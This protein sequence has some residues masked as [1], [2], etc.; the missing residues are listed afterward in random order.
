MYSKIS[1]IGTWVTKQV[2]RSL[3]AYVIFIVVSG[4]LFLALIMLKQLLLIKSGNPL[5]SNVCS[6]MLKMKS[7][8]VY[9]ESEF[10]VSVCKNLLNI[11]FDGSISVD[12]FSLISINLVRTSLKSTLNLC[13][14]VSLIIS[15]TSCHKVACS[16]F[17]T[18]DCFFLLGSILNFSKF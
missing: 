17:L 16:S 15:I 12:L 8:S 14:G 7:N 5:I 2:T 13:S 4:W 3:I 18:S 11:E 9:R 6:N 10:L 1:E